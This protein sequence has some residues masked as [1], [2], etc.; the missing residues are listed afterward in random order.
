MLSHGDEIG[1][2]QR[3]NNNAYCQD[4]ELSWVDWDGLLQEHFPLL[5]FVQRLSRLRREHPVFR[6]RRF[7][8]GRLDRRGPARARGDGVSVDLPDLLW[9]TPGGREMAEADWSAGFNKSFYIF[10]NGD[11]ISEPGR[12]GERIRDDSFLLLFNAHDGDLRFVLPS[13]LYGGMWSKVIDTADP[14]L[15]EEESPVVKA[16]ESVMMEARSLQVL[17]RV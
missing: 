16:G 12:R 2:T 1:R 6:R 10:L 9:F 17:R 5:D 7:F 4:S 11:A 13:A 15:A 8:Q 14:L 3:G